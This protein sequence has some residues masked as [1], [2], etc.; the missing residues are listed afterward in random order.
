[1]KILNVVTHLDPMTGGGNAERTRQMSLYLAKSGMQVTLLTTDLGPK[2][3]G[4]K[5]L[6]GVELVALP[7]L[8]RRFYVPVPR[9]SK[10]KRAVAAADLVHLM[11]H[12]SLLNALVYFYLRR[13][14]KPYVVCPAGALPIAGRSKVF[15][16]IYNFLIGREIIQNAAA[17]ILVTASELPRCKDYRIEL[18]KVR[19][20]P[21][22]IEPNEATPFEVS[23]FREKIGLGANPFILFMGR[24]NRLKGPDLLLRAFCEAMVALPGYHLVFAGPDEGLRQEMAKAASLCGA[25]TRVHFW[26]YIEEPA[27]TQAYRAADLVVIPSRQEAMSIVVLEAGSAGTPVLLT[28]QC[29]FN[30]VAAINGGEVVPA[31]VAGLA[32]GLV[33]MLRDPKKLARQGAALKRYVQDHFLWDAIVLEYLE[34]YRKLLGESQAA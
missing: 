30:E 4:L 12:W 21:N 18:A 2:P 33:R 19:V 11:G 20:I 9:L 10:I 28:D 22:G 8:I 25:G 14:K 23:E 17:H 34:L 13:L 16:V 6:P 29:G 5:E 32:A 1:M 7:S 3:G 26:G 31:S 15:K 24:L 27:K